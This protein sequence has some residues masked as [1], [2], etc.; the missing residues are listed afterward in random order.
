MK[1]LLLF[2]TLVPNIAFANLEFSPSLATFKNDDEQSST[3]LEFRLGYNFELAADLGL[4]VGGFYNIATDKIIEHVDQ[5][6]LGPQIGLNYKGLYTL[7]G[8]TLTGEQDLASGGVKY[9]RPN[10]YQVSLGYRLPLAEGVYLSPEFTW[11]TVEYKSQEIQGI[12]Q[13]DTGRKDTHVLPSI[14]F[15]FQF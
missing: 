13:G 9:S 6:F 4:Y 15:M 1:S 3:Q 5:Y 12:P 10:G 2:L 8:Y 7:V 14:T 11:R